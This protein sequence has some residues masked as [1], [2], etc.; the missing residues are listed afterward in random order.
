MHQLSVE[1]QFGYARI[2]P[3]YVVGEIYPKNPVSPDVA[4]NIVARVKEAL[5]LYFS[6]ANREF[7][8]KPTI[9]EVVD[10]IENADS[11]IKYFDAGGLKNPVIV[12]KEFVK[13][14]FGNTMHISYD[15]EYFN[16]ISFAQ[17]NRYIIFS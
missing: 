3:W 17:Y 6:P 11:R 8:Q 4:A 15:I 5:A 7:G 13:N 14:Q 2:F 12:Y 1:L 9:M 10:V 16:P